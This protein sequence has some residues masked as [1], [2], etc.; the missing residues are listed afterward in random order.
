VEQFLSKLLAKITFLNL[1]TQEGRAEFATH[2]GFS[3][4]I[5][6]IAYYFHPEALKPAAQIMI[7][8]AL[9]KELILDG[10]LHRIMTNHENFQERRDLI[11][12]LFS[13]TLAP[14]MIIV[15]S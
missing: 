13:R 6:F 9:I 14:V 2:I 5:P 1:S 10:H 4:L 3:A 11:T 15:W 7:I 12:D 8:Y